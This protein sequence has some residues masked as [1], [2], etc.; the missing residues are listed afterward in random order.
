[1]TTI[2]KN[3]TIVTADLTYKADVAIDGGKI[4]EIGENL[5]GDKNLADL[6]IHKTDTG[7]IRPLEFPAFLVREV[8]EIP[9]V[10][11]GMPDPR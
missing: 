3:G 6:C 1:M 9:L 2:I 8:S 5:Q 4:T 10:W 11:N 7:L